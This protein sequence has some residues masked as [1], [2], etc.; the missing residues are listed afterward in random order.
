MVSVS[1]IREA[2]ELWRP[3]VRLFALAI[4]VMLVVGSI[5]VIFEDRPS[6][7]IKL[8][9]FGP[10]YSC[11]PGASLSVLTVPGIDIML[12]DQ[13]YSALFIADVA[14]RGS[15]TCKV[16]FEFPAD[17][18]PLPGGED[19]QQMRE[20]DS[21]DPSLGRVAV[22]MAPS[23]LPNWQGNSNFSL[24]YG[25]QTTD[26]TTSSGWSK[27]S[28]GV[29]TGTFS[30]PDMTGDS[31]FP[32]LAPEGEGARS[33][34]LTVECPST[35]LNDEIVDEYPSNATLSTPA[36]A[37]WQVEPE[38]I[39]KLFTG[40]CQNMATRFW[41][42]HATDG[43]ILGVGALLG[44]LV[45][46]NDKPNPSGPPTEL[47]NLQKPKS[48]NRWLKRVILALILIRASRPK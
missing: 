4:S 34:D 25:F 31:T 36:E 28:F 44:V 10:T 38:G 18:T 43:M 3:V 16:F 11:P 35:D 9:Y 41:V 42:G 30:V 7:A 37:V 26:G 46:R 15:G 47:E 39:G 40:T 12:N 19:S 32:A 22:G 6:R 48:V 2:A 23:Y 33:F 13:G 5:F 8:S 17:S 27:E 29:D 14:S 45:T 20:I 21:T 24:S 1:S